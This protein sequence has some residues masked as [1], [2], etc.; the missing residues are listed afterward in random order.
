MQQPYQS[1]LGNDLESLE[2][3]WVGRGERFGGRSDLSPLRGNL[4]TY[5]VVGL[6]L[7]FGKRT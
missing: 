5:R 1:S 3:E 7:Q 6:L 4:L 2:R